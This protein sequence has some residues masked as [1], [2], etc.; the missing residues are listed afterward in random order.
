MSMRPT[1]KQRHFWMVWL[2][3]LGVLYRGLIPA[4]FMPAAGEAAAHGALFVICPHGE[5]GMSMAGMQM[6]GMPM[7]MHRHAGSSPSASSLE[8]CPFGAAAVPALPSLKTA[9]YF[10]PVLAHSRPG[11]NAT[12][13]RQVS[14]RLQPPARAPPVLS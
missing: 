3:L 14:P 13:S 8:Q 7:D 1:R 6:P 10:P 12:L 5:M 11:W 2:V 4:G 9:F